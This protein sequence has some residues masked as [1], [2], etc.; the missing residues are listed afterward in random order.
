MQFE[1]FLETLDSINERICRIFSHPAS[2]QDP[3][4]EPGLHDLLN[5]TARNL[6]EVAAVQLESCLSESWDQL[7]HHV[8]HRDFLEYRADKLANANDRT[9]F[10]QP[11]PDTVREEGA[12]LAQPVVTVNTRYLTNAQIKEAN[13][14]IQERA[15]LAELERLRQSNENHE[16]E[17][18]M[19]EKRRA[20]EDAAALAA[21]K[22]KKK[23]GKKKDEGRKTLPAKAAAEKAGKK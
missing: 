4:D 1:F 17:Q 19:I 13:W 2:Q 21:A 22:N 7:T 11:A 20:R 3:C 15:R 18:L 14:Q 9:K 10:D 23:G 5:L 8:N 12:R 16:K 6:T